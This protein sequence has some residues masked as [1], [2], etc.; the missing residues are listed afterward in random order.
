MIHL[1]RGQFPK[2]IKNLIQLNT[3]KT[4]QFKKWAKDLNA[5]FSKEYIQMANRPMKKMLTITMIREIQIKI[6]MRFNLTPVRM[7]T[8]NKSTNKCWSGYGEKETSNTVGGNADW[9]SYCGKQ[10]GISSEN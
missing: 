8:I 1:I 2:C 6:T 9:C 4:I 7:A 5:H 10:H 3:R